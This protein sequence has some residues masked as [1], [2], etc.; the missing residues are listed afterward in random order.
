MPR[1]DDRRMEGWPIT[2][3]LIVLFRVW[4]KEREEERA[5]VWARIEALERTLQAVLETKVLVRKDSAV[6]GDQEGQG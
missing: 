5:E 6:A 3:D 4:M 1:I 2:D